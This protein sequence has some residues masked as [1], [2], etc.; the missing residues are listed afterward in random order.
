MLSAVSM[1]AEMCD[2][3]LPSV[4][5]KVTVSVPYCVGAKN[6]II[7]SIYVIIYFDIFSERNNRECTV[8]N[9]LL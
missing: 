9:E 1:L 2:K 5:E 7:K 8:L 3:I 6:M 4:G